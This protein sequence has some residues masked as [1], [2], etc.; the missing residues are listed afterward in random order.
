MTEICVWAP[1]PRRVEVRSNGK[2]LAMHPGDRGW[3]R[4]EIDGP[5]YAF[6][7]D[8]GDP[9]P[10]PRSPWQ[11]EGV[12]G[13]SRIVDHALFP[14]TDRNWQA[15]PLASAIVYELHIGTFTPAGTFESAIEKLD[16]L[17]SLGITHVELMPVQ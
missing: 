12:H 6:L 1:K 3:W 7:L 15:P 9:L 2:T 8:G 17:K 14:W 4:G 16:Y 13:P 5:D 10:D 11:P